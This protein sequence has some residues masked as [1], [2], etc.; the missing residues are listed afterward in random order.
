MLTNSRPIVAVVLSLIS[1]IFILGMG[2]VL[3]SLPGS[4]STLGLLEGL[5]MCTLALLLL[6]Y[7][8][9][10]GILG[11]FIIVLAIFS[12]IGALGGL[13]LGTVF[14][15]LGGTLAVAWKGPVAEESTVLSSNE[16]QSVIEA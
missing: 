2:L 9:F 11:A 13:V 6:A 3:M 5:V 14:G 8:K 7:P 10:S 16:E 1:G 12:I 15:M 4:L